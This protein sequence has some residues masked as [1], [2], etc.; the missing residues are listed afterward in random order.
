MS[1]LI[2]CSKI[3]TVGLANLVEER[4][5]KRAVA[6][7]TFVF[8]DEVENP[9]RAAENVRMDR[10][11]IVEAG[12]LWHVA[13]DEITPACEFAG[14]GLGHARRDLEEGRFARAVAADKPNVFALR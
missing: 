5:A 8:G 3:P 6:R 1:D 10:G 9:L 14:I 13:G 4:G 11:C 2:R 7:D 12:K